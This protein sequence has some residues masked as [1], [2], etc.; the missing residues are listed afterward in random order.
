LREDGLLVVD[1][2]YDQRSI[3]KEIGGRWDAVERAWVVAF[4]S[5]NLEYLLDRL[6]DVS[7]DPSIESRLLIQ[8][9]KE[10]RL[11]K[12]REMAKEDVMVNLQV[13]G[14]KPSC[15]L[16]NYQKLG[17]AYVLT[18]GEGVL[19]ADEMGLG[20]EVP[21]ETPVL[22][23]DGWAPI[24][25][26]KVGD[27]V[28]ARDGELHCIT[29]VYPQGEKEILKIT[30]SDGVVA[31]CGWDHLW[32]VQ[33]NSEKAR[34]K[35]WKE[36]D[37]RT[38]KADLYCGK[39]PR[40][41]IPLVK[42]IQ[43]PFQSV[44]VPPY[45][46][47]VSLYEEQL[48]LSEECKFIPDEY[49]RLSVEQRKQL[50]AGLLDAAGLNLDCWFRSLDGT[51]T[52][53]ISKSEILADEI[54]DLVRGL[55]GMASKVFSSERTWQVEIL[56][57]F[58]PFFVSNMAL[59]WRKPTGLVRNVVAIEP[60]RKAEAICIAVDSPDSTFLIKDFIVTHNTLQFIA[61]VLVRKAKG[62]AKNCLVITP[63]SLKFNWPLEIEKFTDEKY[64]VIDGSP[65]ERVAQWK[66]N[67]VFFYIVNYELLLEDLFGG[68]EFKIRE[69]DSPK[70][71]ARKQTQKANA[72]IR[73]KM[74]SDV[75]LRSWDAIVIDE[76]QA[77]KSHSSKK[78]LNV[79][80]L[81]GKFRVALTG[82][83]MDGRLEELHSVMEFVY[84][85]LLESRARFLQKHAETDF[86]GRI[87]GYRDIESVRRRIAHCFLR[88]LKKNVLKD[89]PDKIYENRIVVLSSKE[90]EIYRALASKGHEV[91]KDAEAVVAI[92]RCKQF[93]DHPELLDEKQKS[94]KLE[95][96]REVLEEVVIENGHKVLVFSQYKKML[97]ILVELFDT[98]GFSYLRIDGDTP[99]QLRA[100]YQKQFNESHKLDIMVGT[101][102]M[103]AGLNFTSADYVINYDDNWAPAIMAQ[104]EDR[105][106]RLGQKNAVTVVNFICKD[107][108]EERIRA[109]LYGKSVVTAETM[110]DETDE[111]V[112][113]RL[114]PKDIALL[115]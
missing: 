105:C 89:L 106:H 37:T 4:T 111:M 94:S 60:A 27:R 59:S 58:N 18:N 14:L 83:P 73:K 50:L 97:E 44:A 15:R 40:W 84:P 109:V 91:T 88:R 112:L 113:R 55:G 98:M 34:N 48:R 95:S 19:I 72:E 1:C 56:T 39:K 9:E 85:G 16:Y 47:G 61:A 41:R 43:Y 104:R 23:E 100:D 31:E 12:L 5:E 11:E 96:L 75:R 86:W 65:S 21:V 30:F 103:S 115:L 90:M 32:L 28:Y 68:K 70:I 57:S 110:G 51:C 77:I 2:E 8:T 45:R 99:K 114:G 49:K 64:V 52:I 107:T 67:D 102:A 80:R 22:G 81:S 76:A 35:G 66:R 79:K 33:D 54:I 24:G 62:Q 69:D 7:V 87:T 53:F 25:D 20:K 74:L 108:I 3:P 38:M 10:T 93:C 46:L 36:V 92:V 6:N 82:T 101:E 42:P 26:V 78:S 17:V 63:A 71:V 13:S 29:G